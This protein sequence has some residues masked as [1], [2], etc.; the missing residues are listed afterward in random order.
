MLVLSRRPNEALHVGDD[1]VITVT[2]VR[3]DVVRLGI[4]AP[5]DVKIMRGELVGKPDRKKAEAE[6]TETSVDAPLS[7]DAIELE[8][9]A[10]EAPIGNGPLT[11]FLRVVRADLASAS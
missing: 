5:K 1:I 11:K 10:E 7:I 4:Q 8:S 2:R 9:D 6:A 3:G